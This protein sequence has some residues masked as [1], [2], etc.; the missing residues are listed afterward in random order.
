MRELAPINPPPQGDALCDFCGRE[1]WT[2]DPW[3][4][5]MLKFEEKNGTVYE[6]RIYACEEC[7]REEV[8]R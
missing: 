5:S 8:S 3:V 6:R 1:V 2:T 4:S 7:V